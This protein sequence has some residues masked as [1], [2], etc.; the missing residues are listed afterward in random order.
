MVLAMGSYMQIGAFRSFDKDQWTNVCMIES[1]TST[2]PVNTGG[3]TL[4]HVVPV[5]G[6][7]LSGSTLTVVPAAVSVQIMNP[8]ALQTTYGI[9]AGAVCHTQL[10]VN[11]RVETYDDL[12]TEVLSYFKPRLM[13]AAKLALR[14]VQANSYPLNMSSIADFKPIKQLTSADTSMNG[15]DVYPEGWA[16]IVLLNPNRVRLQLLISIEW[17]VRFDLGNPAVASHAHHGVTSDGAWDS[18]IQKAVSLGNGMLDIAEKVATV[19]QAVAPLL[20]KAPRPPPV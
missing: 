20:A 12:S 13:A 1:K 10:D 8:S 17:R 3:N 9:M 15:T 19:G 18:A 5:P 4:R 11:D 2:D 14:G 16:P 7:D 6:G